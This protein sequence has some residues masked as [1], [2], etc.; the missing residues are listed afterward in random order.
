[1]GILS[2]AL[3][4]I[5]V[6]DRSV[7][8]THFH[9]QL[10]D[11]WAARQLEN[12]D[13]FHV[14]SNHGLRCVQRAKAL[15]AITVVERASAHPVTQYELL[16]REF[17]RHGLRFSHA[18][19]PIRRSAR[20]MELADYILIPSDFARQSCLAQ[21]LQEAKLI[22]VPFGVD[23]RRFRPRDHARNRSPFRAL[24]VGQI[25]LQKGVAYLL[26]AWKALHWVDAELWLVGRVSPE[27]RRLLR[28][29]AEKTIR[30]HGYVADPSALYRRADV[31]VFPSLQ[32]GSALATYEAL[33]SGLP[34]LTTPHSG[35]V[36]RDGQEG[37]V[38][39]IRSASRLAGAL[40]RLRSDDRMRAD[41]GQAARIRAKQFT[42]RA[43][44]DRLVRQY[45]RLTRS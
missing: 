6:Y 30:L 29:Y 5:A 44:G 42:W 32:E 37:I 9:N 43:Y 34:V 39:P 25:S 16:E 26:E 11:L 31:F 28:R 17:A 19:A 15:G 7:R 1:M 10:Y 40:E 12:V 35:S 22:Q 36:A 8:I 21:G 13:L 27:M 23:V 14:W 3:R 4:R 2:R 18:I 33:A 38:V 20:E 24:F 41:M 45:R